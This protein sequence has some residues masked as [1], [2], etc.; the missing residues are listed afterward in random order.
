VKVKLLE[1]TVNKVTIHNIPPG[2]VMNAVNG[3]FYIKGQGGA[4]N[5]FTNVWY[6]LNEFTTEPIFI[7]VEGAFVEGAK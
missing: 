4:F 3:S 7:V 2:T 6:P 5:L 1:T